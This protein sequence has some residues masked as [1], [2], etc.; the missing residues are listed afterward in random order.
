M[1]LA[2]VKLPSNRE[3]SLKNDSEDHSDEL[4]ASNPK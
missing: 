4:Q 2:E 1:G 3:C